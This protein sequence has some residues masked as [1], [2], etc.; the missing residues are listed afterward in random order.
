RSER[1]VA[2]RS[3]LGEP[4]LAELSTSWL[5]G[6]KTTVAEVCYHCDVVPFLTPRRLVIVSGLLAQ[7][8][9]RQQAGKKKGEEPADVLL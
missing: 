4:E 3:A 1:L 7:L 8:K 6:R 5:D 9:R 2:I